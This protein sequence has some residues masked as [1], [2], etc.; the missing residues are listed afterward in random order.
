MSMCDYSLDFVASRP[1]KIG[2][3]LV[4][5][6]FKNSVTQAR[7]RTE[8]ILFRNSLKVSMRAS[9]FRR[10]SRVISQY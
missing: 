3:K 7:Y 2:D 5:T 10:A 1:A 4:T 9:D 6:K 8:R